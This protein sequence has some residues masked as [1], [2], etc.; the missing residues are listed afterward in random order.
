VGL[1][2]SLGH[3]GVVE[4]EVLHKLRYGIVWDIVE[5]GIWGSAIL[6]W[7]SGRVKRYTIVRPE[8]L[9]ETLLFNID[10]A[11]GSSQGLIDPSPAIQ[12]H[13]TDVTACRCH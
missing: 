3:H 10:G 11:V 8:Y 5:P 4:Y 13:V 1:W 12:F 2:Q 7:T 6:I 9:L